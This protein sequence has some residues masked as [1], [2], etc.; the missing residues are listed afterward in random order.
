M[1]ALA[2]VSILTRLQF[3][4]PKFTEKEKHKQDEEAQKPFSVKATGEF[5]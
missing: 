1:G 4:F 5:T 3:G 2:Y